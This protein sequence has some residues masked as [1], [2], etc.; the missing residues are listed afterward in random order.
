MN[1]PV[2]AYAASDCR[3]IGSLKLALLAHIFLRLNLNTELSSSYRG[4]ACSWASQRVERGG[5]HKGHQT[6]EYQRW[7][8]VIIK[9]LL[10]LKIFHGSFY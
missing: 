6:E 8:S 2:S 10:T 9:R 3:F 1:L 5:H 7:N 4:D